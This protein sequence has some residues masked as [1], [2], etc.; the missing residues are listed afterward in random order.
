M[1]HEFYV[2]EF[3]FVQQRP[4]RP[5]QRVQPLT[6]TRIGTFR[7]QCAEFGRPTTTRCGSCSKVVSQADYAAWVEPEAQGRPARGLRPQ[8]AGSGWSPRTTPGTPAAWRWPPAACSLVAVSN[9]DAG[10]EH[11][12]RSTTAP[13]ASGP[14]FQGPRF[15]GVAEQTFQ[16]RPRCPRGRTTFQCDVHG[17][18][19]S[20]ALIVK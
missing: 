13:S 3:L 12:F 15:V 18:A 14:I 19:M 17:P 4:A 10:I 8:R 9:L 1:V 6:L 11:N 5:P 7:G 16:L 2:P 20:G